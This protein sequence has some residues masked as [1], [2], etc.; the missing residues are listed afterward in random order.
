MENIIKITTIDGDTI[1]LVITE[2]EHARWFDDSSIAWTKDEWF[3]RAFIMHQERYLND[4]LS[5]RGHLYLNEVYDCLSMP[6]TRTGQLVGWIYEEGKQVKID[7]LEVRDDGG[8]LLD[9]NVDGIIIDK[10]GD[11]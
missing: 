6:R 1:E 8:L 5:V 4:V 10:M 2:S 7:I 3:N 9:F 11:S